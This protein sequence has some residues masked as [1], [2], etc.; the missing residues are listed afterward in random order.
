MFGFGGNSK[1]GYG[2]IG[3]AVTAHDVRLAQRG[4]GGEY[5]LEHEALAE[6][7]DPSEAT[8]HTETSRA[9]ATAMRRGDFVGKQVVSA[10]PAEMLRYKTLRLPPMPHDDMVQAIAWEA[11]ERF[12]LTDDQALQHY[13]AGEVQQGNERREEVILLAAEKAAIHDH[14]SAVKRAGLEPFAIDATGAALSRL[15]GCDGTSSLIVQVGP[16]VAEIVGARGT[17]VIFD[18]PVQI[19]RDQKEELDQQALAREVGLCLRYLSVTFGIHKPD[20]AWVC[21]EGVDNE[22]IEMLGQTLRTKIQ[23]VG[24][25]AVMHQVGEPGGDN[26][27]WAVAIGLANRDRSGAAQRGAA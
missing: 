5:T 8:Y 3:L 25:A 17:Q 13:S 6:G 15:L 18:K 27:A 26:A 12:Q 4:P 21:G 11:A 16:S 2:P 20:G 9:I 24:E 10:L 19:T 14:A 23:T 22:L 7:V 1:R